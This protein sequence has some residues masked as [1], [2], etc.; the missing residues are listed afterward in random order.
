MASIKPYSLKDGTQKYEVLISHGINRGTGKQNRIHK[1]GFSSYTEAE[2]YAKITE[3]EIASGGYLKENPQSMTIAKFL[4][5]WLTNYKQA[6]KE[7]TRTVHRNN[8]NIY[9]IPYIGNFKLQKYTRVDHQKFIN[10]LFTN[11]GFG[12]SGHGFA[13]KTVSSIHHTVLNAFNKA[14]QLGYLKENPAEFVEFP[15][16]EKN[17]NE[18]H[19]YTVDESEK[20]LKQ[21]KL[22]HAIVWYPFFSTLLD[23]GLRKGEAMGL[24]WQDID[25]TKKTVSIQR[26]RLVNEEKNKYNGKILIDT[27]KTNSSIRQLPM[28]NRLKVVLLEFRNK[29]IDIFG[30]VNESQFI[31]INCW[32]KNIGK[33]IKASSVAA[34]NKRIAERASVKEIKVHDFRHTFAVRLRE[35][36]VNIEDIKD[37]LGHSDLKATQIYAQISPIVKERS[38]LKLET[39]L[40]ESKKEHSN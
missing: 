13:F 1:R 23:L 34:A 29:I 27:P 17:A 22:E 8:I 12:R 10:F 21:A 37:L 11:E 25:F 6:V 36:G 2:K 32:N 24:Q 33:P 5:D 9:L 15:R 30:T 3:G 16:N 18:I 40:E 26:Q 4:N 7:G 28:T 38:I 14:V 39:Y 19:Y 20:Y 31:F 35:A